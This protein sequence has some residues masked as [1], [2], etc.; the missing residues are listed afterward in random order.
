V[1]GGVDAETLVICRLDRSRV[2]GSK[3]WISG[4]GRR[5]KARL[6]LMSGIVGSEVQFVTAAVESWACCLPAKVGGGML[7]WSGGGQL[8]GRTGRGEA[9]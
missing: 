1:V 2:C 3:H 8:N 9:Q 4:L 5:Q 7:A 6:Q